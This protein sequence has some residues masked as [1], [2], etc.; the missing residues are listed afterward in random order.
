VKTNQSL[1]L[2]SR[3]GEVILLDIQRD[4][5]EI[6]VLIQRLLKMGLDYPL[7]KAIRVVLSMETLTPKLCSLLAPSF[8]AD[9]L[10]LVA[11]ITEI[12]ETYKPDTVY[13]KWLYQHLD[14][15]EYTTAE[16]IDI[17]KVVKVDKLLTG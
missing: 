10:F 7:F 16:Y 3:F 11:Y 2:E 12:N 9:K 17:D 4:L 14:G 1:K 6:K 8:N 5:P 13:I 15:L